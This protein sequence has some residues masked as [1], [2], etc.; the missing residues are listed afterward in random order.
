MP[1][2]QLRLIS[3]EIIISLRR[4]QPR[5]ISN[6][7][8]HCFFFQIFF[9]CDFIAFIIFLCLGML[10]SSLC[11]FSLLSRFQL[12]QTQYTAMPCHCKQMIQKQQL[13]LY[14]NLCITQAPLYGAFSFFSY[15]LWVFLFTLRKCSF[16]ACFF[17]SI[18]I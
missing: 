18:L 6:C 1:P 13:L 4:H 8:I 5:E 15:A 7:K 2:R 11:G 3:Y 12:P 17:H 10:D 14:L 9:L 16:I